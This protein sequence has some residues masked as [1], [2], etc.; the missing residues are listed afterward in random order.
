MEFEE[1]YKIKTPDEVHQAGT[2]KQTGFPSPATHYLESTI[3]LNSIL[4]SNRDA[5][6]FIRISGNGW[7]AYNILNQDVLIIDRAAVAKPGKL[8]LVV[9]AGSFKIE[10]LTAASA[11]KD[12]L[13]VWGVVTYIIH[14][15]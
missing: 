1:L 15:V 4:T 13:T 11:K 7:K 12:E 8:A 6:F 9:K 5:T 3:D 10:R 2:S 14:S